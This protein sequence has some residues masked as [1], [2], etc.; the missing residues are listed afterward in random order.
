MCSLPDKYHLGN[1]LE[2]CGEESDD[3]DSLVKYLILP[4]EMVYSLFHHLK[5][6]SLKYVDRRLHTFQLL[7][8][9]E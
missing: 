1:E 4:Y 5:E 6:F 3:K 9:K 8:Y 7:S 2:C